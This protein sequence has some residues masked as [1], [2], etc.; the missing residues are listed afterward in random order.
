MR[1]ALGYH[2]RTLYYSAMYGALS[3]S[4]RVIP[5]ISEKSSCCKGI[6]QRLSK[7]KTVL[8]FVFIVVVILIFSPEHSQL[9]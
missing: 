6:E 4:V 7:V 5:K 2:Q 8:G 9:L 3:P 1:G